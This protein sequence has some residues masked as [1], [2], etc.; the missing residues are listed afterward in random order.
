MMVMVPLAVPRMRRPS[1]SART[2]MASSSNLRR[3]PSLRFWSRW[4]PSRPGTQVTRLPR[5]V[6]ATASLEVREVVTVRGMGA[7][8]VGLSVGQQKK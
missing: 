8:G 5:A 3:R 4:S 2:V 6:P 1:V 7:G